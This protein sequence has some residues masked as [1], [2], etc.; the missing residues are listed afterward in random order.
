MCLEKNYMY[1]SGIV[2][3]MIVKSNTIMFRASTLDVTKKIYHFT[4]SN[5]YFIILPHHFTTSYL[6][7][8]LLFNSIH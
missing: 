6:S 1:L 8:I 4:T 3:I 7:D 5:V 2:L